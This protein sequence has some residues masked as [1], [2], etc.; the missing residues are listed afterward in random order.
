MTS[1]QIPSCSHFPLLLLLLLLLPLSASPHSRQTD[2]RGSVEGS[3]SESS[4]S[5]GSK[6]SSHGGFWPASQVLSAAPIVFSRRASSSPLDPSN[7]MEAAVRPC[8]AHPIPLQH[9]LSQFSPSS[10]PPSPSPSPSPSPYLFHLPIF[11]VFPIFPIFSIYLNNSLIS[12]PSTLPLISLPPSLFLFLSLSPQQTSGGSHRRWR[13]SIRTP[14]ARRL[15]QQHQ[16]SSRGRSP[17]SALS[18]LSV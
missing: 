17:T 5:G 11:P 18:P 10:L 13:P 7:Y 12:T 15:H 9:H 14:P 3:R 2:G 4:T 1:R 6:N 16:C 8:P